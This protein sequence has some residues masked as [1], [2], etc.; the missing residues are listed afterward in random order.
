MLSRVF[1]LVALTFTPLVAGEQGSGL[2]VID[3]SRVITVTGEEYAPGMVVIEDGEITLVGQNLDVP[4]SARRIRARGETVMPGMILANTRFGLPRGMRNGVYTEWNALDEVHPEEIDARPFVEAGFVAV[5]YVPAGSGFTGQ[6]GV[7][8]PPLHE[9]TEILRRA[10]YLPVSMAANGRDRGR[11]AQTF[12][13]A[14]REIEKAKKAKAD[15]DKKQ[16]E[17]KKR[18]EA[19]EQQKKKQ[20]SKQGNSRPPS[21]GGSGKSGGKPAPQGKEAEKPPEFVPPKI[22]AGL[23]PLV[24]I[25]R[26]EEDALPIVFSVANA[27]NLLHLA[28]AI[29]DYEPLTGELHRNVRFN[30]S[31]RAEQRPMVDLLGGQQATAIIAPLITNLPSTLT[32]INL[33]RELAAAGA[34]LIFVPSGDTRAEFMRLRARVADLIRSGLPREVGLRALTEHPAQFLGIADR[35]GAIEKGRSAD[36]IF[37]D[38][39]PFDAAT[40]VTRTMIAGEIVWEEGE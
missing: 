3:A 13:R 12:E 1:L 10:A 4:S 32:R 35:C 18:R 22:P 38:G 24:S 2:W 31:T 28:E 29:G 26:E 7:M 20:Q 6:A 33:P 9:E 8:R 17:A 19:E 5:T 27:G 36:L 21:K 14:Q 11:I 30:P 34:R 39:D 40:R 25:L 23:Q 15:W 37:L 16:E